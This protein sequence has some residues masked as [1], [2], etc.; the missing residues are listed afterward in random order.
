MEFGKS[1]NRFSSILISCGLASLALAGPAEAFDEAAEIKLGEA[2][3]LG[4]CAA[5]HGAAGQGDGPVAA[6]LQAKPPDLTQITAR[7]SGTFP[8]EHIYAMIDGRNMINPHGDRNMPV[9]GDR[10]FDTAVDKAMS[11]PHNLDTQALV[12]GR[13]TALIAYLESIQAD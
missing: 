5:C 11:V 13:I 6:V 2:E 10:Y 1:R 8:T 3:Y 9:W 7:Y 12:H 4:Q